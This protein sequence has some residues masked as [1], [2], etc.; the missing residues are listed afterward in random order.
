VSEAEIPEYVHKATAKRMDAEARK[1]DAEAAKAESDAEVALIALQREQEKR[2][3]E[4]VADKHLYR[5]VFSGGVDGASAKACMDQLLRWAR[6]SDGP[7][8]ATIT[9]NSPGGEV[10]AGF[11]LIDLI[12]DLQAQGHTIDTHSIGMCAS[13]GGVLLQ[14]GDKR[15][16][17]KHAWLLIHEASFGAGGSFG[18]VED[19]VDWVRAVQEQILDLF[20][21][22]SKMTKA[23]IKRRWNRKDWWISASDALKHGFID[24]IR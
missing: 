14:S 18:K 9:I 11:A 20:A 16:M 3:D 7:M 5:Y 21:A 8:Q 24:E 10:V 22:R 4:L 12:R 15:S 6:Q 13:M 23:Q 1:F 2:R 19:Q 17:G